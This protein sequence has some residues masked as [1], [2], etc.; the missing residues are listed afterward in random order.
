MVCFILSAANHLLN[1]HNFFGFGADL[2]DR[3]ARLAVD[4][5]AA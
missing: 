2:P 4:N 1:D 3:L 5:E